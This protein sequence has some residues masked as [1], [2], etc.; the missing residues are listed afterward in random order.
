MITYRLLAGLLVSTVVATSQLTA[1]PRLTE[2]TFE[3]GVSGELSDAK[4]GVAMNVAGQEGYFLMDC[5]EAGVRGNLTYVSEG[6]S[7]DW[8]AGVFGEYNFIVPDLPVVPYAGTGVSVG[9]RGIDDDTFFIEA[10]GWGGAKLFLLD[11]LSIG[12]QLELDF[13]TE[14]IYNDA[15]SMDWKLLLRTSCYF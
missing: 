8:T 3:L 7:V 10:A 12:L 15:D 2:G 4:K 11:S 14:K 13:A 6:S 5:A 1:A 9:Y